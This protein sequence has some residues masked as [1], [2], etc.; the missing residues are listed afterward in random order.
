MTDT[1]TREDADS[2]VRGL[3]HRAREASYDLAL[4]TRAEKD[5]ALLAMAE[6]LLARAPEVLAANADDVARAEDGG[7]PANLVDRLR[8]TGDR[9]AGMAQG[10]RDVAALPYPV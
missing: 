5:A 4:A 7:T 9:L 8:L 3:A 2:L 1:V 10:L 6:A